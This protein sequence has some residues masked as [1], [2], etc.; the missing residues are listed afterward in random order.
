VS[1]EVTREPKLPMSQIDAEAWI[2]QRV[3]GMTTELLAEAADLGEASTLDI[4]VEVVVWRNA[5]RR[6]VAEEFHR[7]RTCLVR[8]YY[9]ED[10]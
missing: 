7:R 3:R 5:N 2:R 1:D 9:G 4:R 10:T 6:E 8:S